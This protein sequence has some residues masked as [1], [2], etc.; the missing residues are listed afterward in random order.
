MQWC[1]P[2]SWTLL[3]A[4]TSLALL[5]AA[6]AEAQ[7]AAGDAK[8]RIAIVGLDHDHVWSMLK[9]IAGEPSAELIAIAEADPA[10]V[11]RAQ[12]EAPPTVKFY[13]D[14]VAM[15]DE[16]KPEAVIVTTSNEIGRAHV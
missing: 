16:A 5:G 4:F 14:Y 9:N 13:S 15:L 1:T 6:V 3:L 2:R 10:L 7:T 12:K 11:S 8:T